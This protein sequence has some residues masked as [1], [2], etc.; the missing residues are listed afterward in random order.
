MKAETKRISLAE[1]LKKGLREGIEYSKGERDLATSVVPLG[2]SYSGQ[3]VVS[4]RTRRNM[5]QAQFA[6]LLAVSVKTLQ[7]WEQGVRKPSKPTM[8]LL[9]IFDQPDAFRSVLMV[10]EGTKPE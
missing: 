4:I 10:R 8:R 6:K 3:D 1:R 7:S 2:I 9:Q 5:S